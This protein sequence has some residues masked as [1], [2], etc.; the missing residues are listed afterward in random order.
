MPKRGLPQQV[1]ATSETLPPAAEYRPQLFELTANLRDPL[2]S[3]RCPLHSIL[4]KFLF[5][6]LDRRQRLFCRYGGGVRQSRTREA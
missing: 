4:G 1:E 5:E 6:G 3:W 2:A